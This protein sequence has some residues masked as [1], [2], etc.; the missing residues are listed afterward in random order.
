MLRKEG[1]IKIKVMPQSL[2][3]MDDLIRNSVKVRQVGEETVDLGFDISMIQRDENTL[4]HMEESKMDFSLCQEDESEDI[5][6]R[7]LQNLLTN[8]EDSTPTEQKQPG[9]E[10][11]ITRINQLDSSY[12]DDFGR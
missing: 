3:E 9:L 8:L 10:R 7:E 12:E 11:I 1:R 5:I 2:V 6:C 4:L